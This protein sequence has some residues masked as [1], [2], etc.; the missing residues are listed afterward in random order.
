MDYN[1]V[2]RTYGDHGMFG[3][4]NASRGTK[5]G[6]E[7]ADLRQSIVEYRIPTQETRAVITDRD[8]EAAARI[9]T[10]AQPSM[11]TAAT[12]RKAEPAIFAALS[13]NST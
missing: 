7:S 12:M 3:R 9:L 4:D 1:T 8:A 13:W 11:T 6:Q 10:E 2:S 5:P